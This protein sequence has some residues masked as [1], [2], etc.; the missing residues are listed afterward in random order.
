MPP[1]SRYRIEVVGKLVGGLVERPVCRSVLIERFLLTY[2]YRK[3]RKRR[4]IPPHQSL[5]ATNCL[6]FSFPPQGEAF[7]RLCKLYKECFNLY[8][9]LFSMGYALYRGA[10][11]RERPAFQPALPLLTNLNHFYPVAGARRQPPKSRWSGFCAGAAGNSSTEYGYIQNSHHVR[12]E[13]KIPLL[14]VLEGS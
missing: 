3:Y 11:R 5:N 12:T 2:S 1:L 9:L 10:I 7:H 14:K 13:S 4:F 8:Q 6:Q